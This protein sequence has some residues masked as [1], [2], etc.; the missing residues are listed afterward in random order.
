[1][2]TASTIPVNANQIDP[3]VEEVCRS[4]LTCQ[5]ASVVSDLWMLVAVGLAVG[6]VIATMAYLKSARPTLE[7][8]QS[9]TT[10]ER[11]DL[12]EFANRVADLS[13]ESTTTAG[14]PAGGTASA[15]TTGH[16][17]TGLDDV[18][19]A[20]RETVMAVPHY[21]EEYGESLEENMAIEL[22]D[23]VAVSVTH[24]QG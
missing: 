12:M 1:M 22:D 19:E 10:A 5:V 24:H 6:T 17:S 9:R 16:G 15:I 14:L 2:S 7:E 20:Y 21:A 8:E 11:D 23:E 3:A 13:V 4:G 18:R